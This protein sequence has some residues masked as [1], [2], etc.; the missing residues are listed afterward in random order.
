MP[1]TDTALLIFAA[2]LWIVAAVRQV[3]VHGG[4]PVALR[5]WPAYAAVFPLLLLGA[6]GGVVWWLVGWVIEAVVGFVARSLA[7]GF[8]LG[9]GREDG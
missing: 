3:I 2:T 9:R 1:P 4:L 5:E 8:D 6:L 7:V